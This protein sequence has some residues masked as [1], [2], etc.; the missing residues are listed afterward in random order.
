MDLGIFK[1]EKLTIVAYEDQ[2][3]KSEIARFEA[4]FNPTSLEQKLCVPL[5]H[6]ST[7]GPNAPALK[8]TSSFKGQHSLKLVLDGTGVDEM[9][10]FVFTRKTV[11]ERVEEFF[12]ATIRVLPKTHEPS[13]L[14]LQWGK[15]DLTSFDCRLGSASVKYTL[16]NRDGTPLRAEL[17]ITLIHDPPIEDQPKVNTPDLTHARVVRSGDTL[18]LLTKDIYGSSVRY[19]DVARY[20]ELDDF[21]NLVPGTRLLFPPLVHFDGDG[22]GRE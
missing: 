10:I 16:F 12:G 20:N 22:S 15:L 19:L 3:R 18:P 5:R 2:K 4:M 17:D 13:Y 1:L 6:S 14:R 7:L 21:R 9:G 8:F 11:T